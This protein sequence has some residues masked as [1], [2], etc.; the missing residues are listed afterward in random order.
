MIK[1]KNSTPKIALMLLFLPLL[2]ETAFAYEK[3]Y[4]MQFLLWKT[5]EINLNYA[6]ILDGYKSIPADYSPNYYLKI[7]SKNNEVYS[8]PFFVSFR[9]MSTPP[10]DAE[11]NN[12]L[13]ELK[14]PFFDNADTIKIFRSDTEIFS[15]DISNFCNKD[16]ICGEYENEISCPQ[17]CSQTTNE[18]TQAKPNASE[19]GC[20]NNICDSS[21]TYFTCPSDCKSGEKDG[22]CD[23]VKDGKCDPDCR[24][25]EDSDCTES[26]EIKKE[27]STSKIL[28]AAIFGVILLFVVLF[29]VIKIKSGSEK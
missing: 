24:A 17:D 11:I 1:M 16:K 14:A 9:I 26:I 20:G 8:L 22:Y 28:I 23:R 18:T 27:D 13:V 7:Y 15:F 3:I 19:Y 25:S 5:G 21:E 12:T 6:K 29:I 4:D 2:T 10:L